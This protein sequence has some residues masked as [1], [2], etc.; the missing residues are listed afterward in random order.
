METPP[1]P[2]HVVIAYDATKERDQYE[3][4]L[5]MDGIRKRGDILR[6]GVNL[7]VLGVLHKVTHPSKSLKDCINI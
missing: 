7:L 2:S 4:R 3:L 5:T 6:D 1:S